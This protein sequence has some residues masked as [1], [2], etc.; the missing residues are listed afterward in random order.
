MNATSPT[1]AQHGVRHLAAQATRSTGAISGH[2]QA[3]AQITPVARSFT[4]R[5]AWC[6]LQYLA[7]ADRPEWT[8]FADHAAEPVLSC[9]RRPPVRDRGE[10][11]EQQ[12]P[13]RRAPA[14]RVRSAACP[15]TARQPSSAYRLLGSACARCCSAARERRGRHEQTT[16]HGQREEQHEA[17][18]LGDLRRQ[19]V[20]DGEAEQRER[21]RAEPHHAEDQQ[22]ARDRQVDV[23]LERSRRCR[24]R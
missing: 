4:A 9:R 6:I 16:E 20:A 8:A 3:P 22:P 21:H 24:P 13:T 2:I 18:R 5:D 1:R 11:R 12:P 10:Q 17:R 15:A 7:I 14:A 19:R 23:V